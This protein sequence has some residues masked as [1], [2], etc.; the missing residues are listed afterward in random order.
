LA[1]YNIVGCQGVP[2]DR[3]VIL[4]CRSILSRLI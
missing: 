2:V 1:R 4:T 3:T